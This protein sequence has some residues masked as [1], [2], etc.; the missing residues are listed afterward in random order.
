M[1]KNNHVIL[2]RMLKGLLWIL[3]VFL[4]SLWC[5]FLSGEVLMHRHG[6]SSLASAFHQYSTLIQCVKYGLLMVVFL[7]WPW[8]VNKLG[9]QKQ[10]SSET[11]QLVSRWRWLFVLVFVLLE[12]RL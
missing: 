1:T 12:V 10:W 8:V 2:K 3:V 6:I 4:V 7:G 9:N 5:V 11:V